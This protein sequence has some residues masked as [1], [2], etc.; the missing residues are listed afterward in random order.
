MFSAEQLLLP[1]SNEQPAGVD[2]AFSP[3][4][5][6]ITLA[7]KFDDPTLDQGEWVADLKEADWDFVV[8]SCAGL[9]AGSSK[10]LRLAVWLTEAGTKRH[11]LRGMAEGLLVLSGLCEKFWDRGLFPEAEDGDQEQRIGNL[12]WIL[13]RIPA[14]LREVPITGGPGGAFST[15][16]F[17]TAR[18]QAAPGDSA[19]QHEGVKL[20]DMEA[21]R[22]NNSAAFCASFAVDAQDCLEALRKLERVVD[23][24]LGNDSPAFSTAREA[25]EAMLRVM[26]SSVGVAPAVPA[27][28]ADG[29]V[30]MAES[31]MAPAVTA[32][33]AGPPGAITTRAQAIE[34]L[35][36]VAQFFRRSEP[37]S[38]V[39]YFADKAANA[40]DQ[41]LHSWLRS[42]VKDAGS[43]AHIEELLGVQP[44]GNG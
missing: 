19:R 35:R 12:S 20:S 33:P 44:P 1:I 29:G 6:A 37:H 27:A 39:S 11:H 2:L 26:P 43:L 22:R 17:E 4:L 10:D 30:V 14:L 9:L 41:D 13:S 24:R 23:A 3:E 40:A 18:R 32:I 25:V 5:D 8:R 34:Q 31:A 16:D 42:V 38:P 36:A 28:A 21:A 15:I 7:R